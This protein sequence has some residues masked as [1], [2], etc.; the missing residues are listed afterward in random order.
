[1]NSQTFRADPESTRVVIHLAGPDGSAAC[2]C[3]VRHYGQAVT[4]VRFPSGWRAIVAEI[5]LDAYDVETEGQLSS[6]AE[7]AFARLHYSGTVKT[8]APYSFMEEVA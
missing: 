1:M 8:A 6:L 5:G 7:T 4:D 2:E 3:V